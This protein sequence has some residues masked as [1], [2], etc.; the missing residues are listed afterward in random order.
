MTVKLVGV[1]ANGQRIGEDHPRAKLTWSDVDR[2]FEFHEEGMPLAV[3]ARK[4]E[5]NRNTVRRILRGDCWTER[6][7]RF[8]A[9]PVEDEEVSHTSGEGR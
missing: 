1:A 2:I 7:L 3:I 4:M 8:K 6:P 9:V 5:V